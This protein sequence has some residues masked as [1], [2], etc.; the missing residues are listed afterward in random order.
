MANIIYGTSG[1]DLDTI[2]TAY[3]SLSDPND[4]IFAGAGNDILTGDTGNDLLFGEDG[5]DSISGG[6]GDDL[7]NGGTDI[8]AVIGS[9]SPPIVTADH[10]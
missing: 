4:I 3:R 9:A 5:N 6:A 1:N 7:L 2:F 10:Y 8:A